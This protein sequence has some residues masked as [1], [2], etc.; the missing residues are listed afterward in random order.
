MTPID[1]L[2]DDEFAHL[3]QRAARLP[4]APSALVRAAIDLWPAAGPAAQRLLAEPAQRR[5]PEPAAARPLADLL[6]RVQRAASRVVTAVLSADSWALPAV[7][8]GLRA[9]RADTRHLLFSAQ[10][11]DIDLRISP[12]AGRYALTGQV[13]GP[14]EVGT[15]ELAFGAAA[16][17]AAMRHA[18][19]DDLGAFRLDGVDSGPVRLTLR[20]G[21]DEI[22]LPPIDVGGA[23]P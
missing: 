22:V 3:V 21:G 9:G 12:S 18:T 17:A 4:D 7:A 1:D 8:H 16:P 14:D 15:V 5:Q 13:L 6:D 10:G 11:R 20:L 23:P 19:L 2:S